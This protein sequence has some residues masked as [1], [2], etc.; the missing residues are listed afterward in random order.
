MVDKIALKKTFPS[1]IL[2]ICKLVFSLR[3]LEIVIEVFGSIVHPLLTK[4]S[5][6]LKSRGLEI[7]K[8]ELYLHIVWNHD[9]L[10]CFNGS[11]Y[12]YHVFF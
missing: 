6:I 11:F 7:P 10:M 4:N 5:Q 8:M 12:L 3:G 9:I 1:S 2:T